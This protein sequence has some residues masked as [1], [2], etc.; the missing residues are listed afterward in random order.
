MSNNFNIHILIVKHLQ[1]TYVH[2]HEYVLS[3]SNINISLIN[4]SKF[5]FS[6][7]SWVRKTPFKFSYFNKVPNFIAYYSENLFLH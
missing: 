2:K 6:C 1:A 5:F 3:M 7:I 4:N